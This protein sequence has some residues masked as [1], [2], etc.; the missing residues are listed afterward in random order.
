MK[1]FALA[2]ISLAA[3]LAVAAYVF[4]TD[5]PAGT[6][7][8]VESPAV[9][10]ETAA[11][12]PDT[13][14]PRPKN[15]G[16]ATPAD[17]PT[18]ERESERRGD[19]TIFSMTHGD[20]GYVD[21]NSILQ[22]RDPYSVVN[23]L[24]AHRDLTGADESLEITINQI[25]ENEKWGHGVLFTQL[26]EE[27]PTNEVGK[28]FFTSSGAVTRVY[29]DILDPQAL[30]DD[31]VLILPPEAEAIAY[32]AARRYAASLE[33]DVRPERRH[34]PWEIAVGSAEIRHRLDSEDNLFRLWEVP[35]TL[36]GPKGD[37]AMASLSPETGDVI[38]V[39]S[40]VEYSRSTQFH[41]RL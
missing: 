38:S 19:L 25:K 18:L 20:I 17:E 6:E 2:A 13:E 14:P 29:G 31:P 34:R 28:I 33:P 21:V 30:A 8:P 5:Q 11:G 1:K 10:K 37:I 22:E 3:V 24:R 26:I 39:R 36:T 12:L 15:P 4:L 35:V 23:L 40:T 16:R 41:W 7:A 27:Q 32:E 9:P